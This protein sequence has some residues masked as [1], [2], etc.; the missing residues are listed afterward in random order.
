M[1]ITCEK[2]RLASEVSTE[3]ERLPLA[4]ALARDKIIEMNKYW[5]TCKV[6]YMRIDGSGDERKVTE[7]YLLDAYNYTEAETRISYILEQMGVG[8][9]EVLQITKSNFNEV[10][11]YDDADHWFRVKVAFVSFDEE[12]GNEKE[13]NQNFLISALDIRDAF[14]KV[15]DFLKH[16]I[17]TCVI[18]SITYTKLVDVFP[19]SEEE[20]G[21]R[22]VRERGLTA[23]PK[24]E[25]VEEE[26]NY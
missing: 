3:I 8:P 22:E 26:E 24:S 18:P 19:L 17:S 25:S 16:T 2:P 23:T 5:F 20:P 11:R 14:D 15:T 9:F 7:Q 6:R 13:S 21:L 1:V 4:S 12:S 10:L